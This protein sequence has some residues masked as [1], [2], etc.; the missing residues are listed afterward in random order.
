MDMAEER[1]DFRVGDGACTGGRDMA[2]PLP[3]AVN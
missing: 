1:V 3:D 2:L